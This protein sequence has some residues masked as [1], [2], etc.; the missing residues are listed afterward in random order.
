MTF[1]KNLTMNNYF[2]FQKLNNAVG[3]HQH[4]QGVSGG[5]IIHHYAGKVFKISQNKH[6]NFFFTSINIL[7]VLIK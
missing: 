2:L 6:A 1:L 3:T 4:F 5:F 7:G